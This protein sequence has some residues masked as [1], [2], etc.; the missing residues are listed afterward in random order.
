MITRLKTY[1]WKKSDTMEVVMFINK[2]KSV[3]SSLVLLVFLSGIADS[4]SAQG[5]FAGSHQQSVK[6]VSQ[7]GDLITFSQFLQEDIFLSGPFDASNVYFS[8]PLSWRLTPG[9][10]L[11]LSM[12]VTLSQTG[13]TTIN[14]VQ[15]AAGNITVTLN[16]VFVGLVPI[17]SSGKSSFQLNIPEN[18][19]LAQK[20]DGQYK[21]RFFLRSSGTCQFDENTLIVI[22]TDSS[23][24]LPHE[25]SLPDTSLINFPSPIFQ[26]DA[27]FTTPVVVVIPDHPTTVELQSAMTVA[28]GLGNISSGRLGM[29]VN[30]VSHLT[31]D[32]IANNN[33]IFIGKAASQPISDQLKFALPVSGGAFSNP[34]GNPDD[35]IIQLLNSPWSPDKVV[36]VVSGNTD[37]ATLKAAQAVSTGI[38]RPNVHPNVSIVD[39]IKTTALP[40][41]PSVDQTLAEMG[42]GGK[43][44]KDIGV[45]YANYKFYIPAGKTVTQDAY[46]ELEYGHSSL[47]Q[48]DRAGIVVNVNGNPVGSVSFTEDTARQAVNKVRFS[49]PPSAVIVGD[50]SLEVKVSLV[51]VDKCSNPDFEAVYANIWPESN[52]HLPLTQ[53]VVNP[54]TSYD[55]FTYP[56]PF[57]YTSTLD[58][59]AFVLQRDDLA[60][61]RDA[62][63]VAAFLGNRSDGAITMLSTFYADELSESVRSKYNFIAI[64]KISQ[65]P[66]LNE[67]NN[68]LPAPFDFGKNV[69]LEPEMQVKYRIDPKAPVGY[70]ELL[71]SPW[72]SEK[73]FLAAV[74]NDSQGVNWAASHLIAPLSWKLAGNFATINNQQVY[75]ADTRLSRLTPGITP[76]QTSILEVVPPNVVNPGAST[77]YRPT[78]I[79]P[80][81]ILSVVLIVITVIAAI[82]FTWLQNRARSHKA[83]PDEPKND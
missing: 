41:T 61:W 53:V 43:D 27:V 63:Q 31:Q 80:A 68:V 21:L 60:S 55:L 47:L 59:T 29:D 77:P 72:N 56:A 69:A 39:S 18:A 17:E 4:V 32:Q 13:Q 51:P 71:P 79:L 25:A 54:T 73:V 38:V 11:N 7:T 65:L 23:L 36:L 40:V 66:I 3:L 34:G 45:N 8:L 44:L 16:D 28:A 19:L 52:L 6:P 10:Q 9:A 64:G 67:I 33:L 12:T 83:V 20:I 15:A 78:W 5:A 35:G 48:Y 57:A 14:A 58:T 42:Y 70:V 24:N 49:L 26:A 62:F 22:H 82:Y 37:A 74:G 2:L 81:L 1:A 76:T 30:L 50:N 75:T 46:F